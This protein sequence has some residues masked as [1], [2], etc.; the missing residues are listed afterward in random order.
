MHLARFK[1]ATFEPSSDPGFDSRQFQNIFIGKLN[2]LPRV[3]GRA[4]AYK[5]DYKY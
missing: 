3:A 1:A 4:A 2:M 5:V